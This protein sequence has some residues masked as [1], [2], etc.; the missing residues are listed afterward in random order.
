MKRLL[1]QYSGCI[2]AAMRIVVG[3]LFWCHGAQ[4]L[5]GWFG[6][7]RRELASVAGAAGLI[8]FIGGA[9][10]AV[11]LLTTLA[12]FI[13]SGEMAFAFF[14]AHFPRGWVPIQ[15]GGEAATMFCF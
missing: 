1:E 6:G 12:A 4:K 9:L 3:F 11:G 10:I 14:M 13:C 15:N 2:Y 5:F 7:T 8:E